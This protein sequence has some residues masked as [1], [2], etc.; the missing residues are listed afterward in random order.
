MVDDKLTDMRGPCSI[1]S[2]SGYLRGIVGQ[3]EIAVHRREERQQNMR[4]DAEGQTHR[5]EGLGRCCLR[6]KHD[7]EQEQR[8]R[9]Q[10][11]P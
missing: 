8:Y 4:R 2:D 9:E 1:K 3:E 7:A 10:D 6:E 11:R 5:I